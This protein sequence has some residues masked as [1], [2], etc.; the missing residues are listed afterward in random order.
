MSA[1][2]TAI[3]AEIQRRRSPNPLIGAMLAAALL[4]GSHSRPM[5]PTIRKLESFPDKARAE[6]KRK[7]EASE[8]CQA[9]KKANRE[10][11]I[12]LAKGGAS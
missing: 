3:N 11:Q 12:R 9:R 5:S 10:R 1:T 6:S 8:K 2:T 4:G 7:R